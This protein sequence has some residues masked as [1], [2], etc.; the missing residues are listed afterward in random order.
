MHFLRF[1]QKF[2]MAAKNGRK[3]IFAKKN[4]VDDSADTPEVLLSHCFQD[5]FVF[6]FYAE[7]YDFWQH[8]PDEKC[9]CG[10]KSLSKLL[11][12]ATFPR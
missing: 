5:K 9:V 2:K 10:T 6:A 11:Y 7:I 8:V 1:T 12:L 3:I 4:L